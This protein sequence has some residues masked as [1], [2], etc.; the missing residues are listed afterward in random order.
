[1]TPEKGPIN[2]N[3]NIT[4]LGENFAPKATVLVGSIVASNIRVRGATSISAVVPAAIQ[5]GEYDIIVEN[6][7]GKRGTLKKGYTVEGGCGCTTVDGIPS[8]IPI[9]AFLMLG[10]ALFLLK[11]R[12]A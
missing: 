10:F 7:D 5:A 8:H 4:I 11:K 12:L 1:M 2:Q 3:V 9:E 6:P